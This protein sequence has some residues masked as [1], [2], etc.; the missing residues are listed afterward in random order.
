MSHFTDWEKTLLGTTDPVGL[1]KCIF[2]RSPPKV[3]QVHGGDLSK[4]LTWKCRNLEIKGRPFFRHNRSFMVVKEHIHFVDSSQ[5][6]L[7]NNLL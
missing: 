7:S 2:V 4:I 3:G 6:T 1:S 5:E